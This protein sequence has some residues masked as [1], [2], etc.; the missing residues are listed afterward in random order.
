MRLRWDSAKFWVR[1]WSLPL[2]V[3]VNDGYLWISILCLHICL[4]YDREGRH[5]P[6]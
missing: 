1:N 5:E 6:E 4:I 2:G 3:F